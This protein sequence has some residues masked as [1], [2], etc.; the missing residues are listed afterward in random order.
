M[1]P[2]FAMGRTQELLY[3]LRALEE[4]GRIPAADLRGQPDGDRRDGA[5]LRAPGGPRSGHRPPVTSGTCPL[6][7]PRFQLTRA[8]EESRAINDVRGP[9]I[10]ISASGMATGGRILHHLRR[11]LPDPKTTVLLVG[12][13]APGT[14]GRLLQDGARTLRIFGED[15]P[16]RARVEAIHGL[17]AHAD[18]NGLL[19]WLRRATG[20]PRR[21]FVVHGDPGPA[22]TLAGR[23]RAELGWEAV[24][25]DYRERVALD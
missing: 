15:V 8:V 3:H 19:R 10:I 24:V 18:A 14:R 12:F 21:I 4:A 13:Q 17:S 1:V 22:D 20:P 7:T 2:A 5:L 6:H 23:I 16:V 25:P 9:A 11:R